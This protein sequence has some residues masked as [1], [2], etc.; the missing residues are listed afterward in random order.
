MTAV[1]MF[2]AGSLSKTL[3]SGESRE[4]LLLSPQAQEFAAWFCL[5]ASSLLADSGGETGGSSLSSDAI[6]ASAE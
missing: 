3:D 1:I 6:A 2:V 5:T 4:T